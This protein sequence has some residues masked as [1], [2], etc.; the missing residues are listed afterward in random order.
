MLGRSFIPIYNVY[1]WFASHGTLAN[2][3][4]VWLDRDLSFRRESPRVWA[5]FLVIATWLLVQVAR[6]EALHPATFAAFAV[7]RAGWLAYMF[8]YDTL[9]GRSLR[10]DRGETSGAPVIL[11]RGDGGAS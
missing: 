5:P 9:V 11:L 1:W 4:D 10:L 8:R 3:V 6:V 2:G 7:V